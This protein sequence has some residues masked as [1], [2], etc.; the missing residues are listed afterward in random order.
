MRPNVITWCNS[1]FKLHVI[2]WYGTEVTI[3]EPR[4]ILGN[5]NFTN[6]NTKEATMKNYDMIY[7]KKLKVFL[8][9]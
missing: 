2:E 4:I 8:I 3:K 9:S 5:P 6:Q 1:R 7:T